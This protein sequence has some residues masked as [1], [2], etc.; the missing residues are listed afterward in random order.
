MAVDVDHG[1]APRVQHDV[2]VTPRGFAAAAGQ[3]A[4]RAT[5]R[6]KRLVA[7][8]SQHLGALQAV[9]RR[10][11][12]SAPSPACCS[13]RSFRMQR[14]PMSTLLPAPPA[15]AGGPAPSA[16][17]ACGSWGAP[18]PLYH[19]RGVVPLHDWAFL[20][21]IGNVRYAS[22][23]RKLRR[24]ASAA[25]TTQPLRPAGSVVRVTQPPPERRAHA[26][27]RSADRSEQLARTTVT[28]VG[29]QPEVGNLEGS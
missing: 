24:A 19:R 5:A 23:G 9:P 8:S 7:P 16:P 17:L 29:D 1:A 4:G 2:A 25:R 13:L 3:L 26:G 6:W 20:Q 12:G 21:I 10:C 18:P 22:A 14:R 27:R 11:G 15:I 28:S